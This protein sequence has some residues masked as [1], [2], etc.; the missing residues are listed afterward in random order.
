MKTVN[1]V[2]RMMTLSKMMR[3]EGKSVGFVPTMGYLH[4]GH[5][6][7]AK[8]ARKHTDIVVMSIFVNPAQFGPGEDFDRYPRDLKRDEELAGSAGVDI[9][10]YPSVKEMYPA[11]YATYVTVERLSEKLCGGLRP[12][13]FKGVATVVTKL[14]GI[15][16][17]DIAYFGQKDAQQAMIIK[18]MAD[19]LNM[20]VEVKVL[21]TIREKDG[22]AMSSR[23]VYLSEGERKD[24]GVLYESL[25]KAEGLIKEGERD[26]KK[27]SGTIRDMIMARPG[28]KIDYVAIVDA[29][30]F[31][32]VRTISG[33]T[34][35]ALAVFVGTTRL[36]DNIIIKG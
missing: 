12:G 14:F 34:L 15:I 7:L 3:K 16:K 32:E 10:F 6:S 17:P 36:I 1:S 2:S 23:N 22:L 11:G 26:A 9:L 31:N 20:G 30:E 35:I 4:E 27:I 18:K 5:L 25:R 8:T 21:P 19:D 29:K 33:E 24:A 13:H 28:V